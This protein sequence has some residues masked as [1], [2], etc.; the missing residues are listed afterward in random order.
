MCSLPDEGEKKLFVIM[1]TISKK[2]AKKVAHVR[3]LREAATR[4]MQDSSA[5]QE[6][7]AA[8]ELIKAQQESEPVVLASGA[9]TT[10]GGPESHVF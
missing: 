7:I 4:D 3:K 2:K 5:R 10:L 9:G 6:K 8:R 1:R